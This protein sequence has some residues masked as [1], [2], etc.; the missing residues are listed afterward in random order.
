MTSII[1]FYLITGAAITAYAQATIRRVLQEKRAYSILPVSKIR[2]YKAYQGVWT[3]IGWPFYI[4]ELLLFH[5]KNNKK[6]S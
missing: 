1:I 5:H 4:I 3:F 2:A 6:G